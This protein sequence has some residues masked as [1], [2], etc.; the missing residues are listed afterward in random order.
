MFNEIKDTIEVTNSSGS[1]FGIYF[2]HVALKQSFNF[3]PFFLFL[4]KGA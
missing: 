2:F 3:F 1:F 4:V